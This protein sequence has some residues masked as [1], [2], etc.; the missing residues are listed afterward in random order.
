M[1]ASRTRRWRVRSVY[2]LAACLG[3]TAPSQAQLAPIASEPPPP[4]GSRRLFLEVLINGVSTHEIEPFLWTAPGGFSAARG[5]LEDVGIKVPGHGG[6]KDMVAVAGIP[7]LAVRFDEAG[8]RIDFT[9]PDSQ[10]R[11]RVYD[12]RGAIARP[13]PPRSD[14]GALANYTLYG[15]SR[16][17][18]TADPAFSG[19]NATLDMRVFS[20]HGTVTQTALL[21]D[22]VASSRDGLR[23]DSAFAFSAPDDMSVLRVGD[24]ISGGL[25]WTRPFRYGGAQVERDF[26]M[27]PDLVTSPV[28]SLSGS[29]AVP[30]TVDV[31]LDNI[32]AF[33]QPVGAGPYQITNLPIVSSAGTARV[34]VTDSSG[35]EVQSSLPLFAYPTLLTGG[36]TDFS[37]DAG[38]ARRFY[39]TASDEYDSQLLG[40]AT[41]RRGFSDDLTFEAHGEGDSRLANG[42][43]GA[44]L[45]LGRWGVL[46]GAAAGSIAADGIGG[47]A[48]GAYSVEFAGIHVDFGSQRTLG[49]YEDLASVTAPRI[50]G[51]AGAADATALSVVSGFSGFA[52]GDPRP[53]RALDRFS[54]GSE[55]PFDKTYVD[56][57]LINLVEADDVRSRIVSASI[58]RP[59]PYGATTFGSVFVDF[60]HGRSAGLSI[61]LTVPIGQ[62]VSVSA[63]ASDGGGRTTSLEAQKSLQATDGSTGWRVQDLEGTTRYRSADAAYRSPYGTVTVGAQEQEGRFGGSAQIDGS[64]AALGGGVFLGNRVEDGFAVVDTGVGGVPVLRDNRPIGVTNPWGKLL[65]PDLQSYQTNT[66][67]IDPSALPATA[68]VDTTHMTISP[69]RNSGVVADFGVNL[70]VEAA[71][72]VLVDAAGKALPPGSK[73]RVEGSDQRFVVGYDG[74]AYIKALHAANTVVVDRGDVDCRAVFPYPADRRRIETIG[75]VPCR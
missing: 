1:R 21:G 43:A 32:K 67:A 62:D 50:D 5:D 33:S 49:R 37:L 35:H 15:T 48:Y 12:A 29:A 24:T 25:A 20:P 65:V 68:E 70:D 23:L 54:I 44:V 41:L 17:L 2:A 13:P 59:L 47:E 36:L 7:R 28:P 4:S 64:V 39:G 55:L 30:S 61:G 31:Y 74:Q 63:G 22:S 52:I 53:P 72:V 69:A 34:V 75:P 51:R 3:W 71:I 27:R 11:A 38:F 16:G 26:S 73:G 10:R 40:S 14:W 58:S 66:I 9:L 46:S 6:P 19:F 45:G 42:G 18:A 56:V 8:Q 60:A 57:S